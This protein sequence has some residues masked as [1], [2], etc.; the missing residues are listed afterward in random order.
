MKLGIVAALKPEGLV[1]T[2]CIGS[3]TQAVTGG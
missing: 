1:Y 3:A 2:I